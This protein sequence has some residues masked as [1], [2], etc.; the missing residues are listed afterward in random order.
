MKI[1]KMKKIFI[2]HFKNKMLDYLYSNVDLVKEQG[3]KLYKRYLRDVLRIDHNVSSMMGIRGDFKISINSSN[4]GYVT[5]DIDGEGN[6]ILTGFVITIKM[7]LRKRD[8]ILMLGGTNLAK[9][10][11]LLKNALKNVLYD[12]YYYFPINDEIELLFEQKGF[13][14]NTILEKQ[15]RQDIRIMELKYTPKPQNELTSNP[16]SDYPTEY[17]TEYTTEDPTENQTQHIQKPKIKF[18]PNYIS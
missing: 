13:K 7:P 1:E 8:D 10:N 17:T 15:F 6:K 3:E 16:S 12:C 9:V 4:E 11:S 14:I 5:Y 18:L 2:F